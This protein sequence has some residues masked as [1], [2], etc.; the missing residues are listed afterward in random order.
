MPRLNFFKKYIQ[1]K[2]ELRKKNQRLK[3]KEN[4]KNIRS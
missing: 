2:D 1:I 3:E 4:K